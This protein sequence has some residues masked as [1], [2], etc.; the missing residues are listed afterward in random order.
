[1]GVEN[2]STYVRC[3]AID[4]P[5]QPKT[6]AKPTQSGASGGKPSAIIA[7]QAKTA[8]GLVI[9]TVCSRT[10]YPKGVRLPPTRALSVRSDRGAADLNALYASQN[11]Y[12]P[13]IILMVVN[14]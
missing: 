4:R 2:T 13:P 1:M 14:A 7:T 10:T 3:T 8:L 12:I 5:K 9:F 6:I 11:K